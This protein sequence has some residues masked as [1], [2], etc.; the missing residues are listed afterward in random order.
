MKKNII[1]RSE[2]INLRIVEKALDEISAEIGISE[3]N[4]G[5]IMV[6]AM[7]A[8]N[9]AIV[10]GNKSDS[11]K[12]VKIE[13]IHKNRLLIIS[14]E[15]QGKGFKYMEIPDPTKPE[16]IENISG[17]GVFLMSKLA[18]KIEFNESGNKVTMSFKDLKT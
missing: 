1:I 12:E 2:I 3:D 18:D 8:V 16:N 5:K 7:E 13:I 6:S 10:H 9:N 17:R 14:V 4:Y 15:D 11:A